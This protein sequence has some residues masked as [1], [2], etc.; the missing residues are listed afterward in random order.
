M[1]NRGLIDEPRENIKNSEITVSN[2]QV[3]I[4][5]YKTRRISIIGSRI[6]TY[7]PF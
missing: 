5:V 6:I 2:K 1:K 7:F 4:Y 3:V